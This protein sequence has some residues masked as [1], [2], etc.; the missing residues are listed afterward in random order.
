MSVM[1]LSYGKEV[2]GVVPSWADRPSEQATVTEGH[3]GCIILTF[4]FTMTNA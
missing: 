4:F 3:R 1:H 2:L